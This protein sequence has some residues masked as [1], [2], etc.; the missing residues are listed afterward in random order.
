MENTSI[1]LSGENCS[2]DIGHPRAKPI[3]SQ[4]VIHTYVPVVRSSYFY[5]KKF[6]FVR[7]R[8]KRTDRQRA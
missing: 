6:A 5:L 7:N 2:W 3:A 8:S 4:S 1:F